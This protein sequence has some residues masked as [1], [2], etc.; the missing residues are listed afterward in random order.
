[1]N[2]PGSWP[3]GSA[4]DKKKR[5]PDS[6]RFFCVPPTLGGLL[7]RTR[8]ALLR[9]V[10]LT[11][12]RFTYSGPFYFFQHLE[13][14]FGRPDKQA[15]ERFPQASG[16]KVAGTVRLLGARVDTRTGLSL[17]RIALPQ[18]PDIRP[19][20]YARAMFTNITAPVPS[21]PEAAIHF[22][23]NGASLLTLDKQ[24]RAHRVGINT[25]RRQGGLEE[26]RKSVVLGTGCAVRVNL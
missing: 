20:G 6:L 3:G 10:L 26:A 4:I 21:V 23:A 5:R 11:Q 24:N 9:P 22:D 16:A 2:R 1:M 19:G 7:G 15:F 12:A 14:A 8:P 18:R 25:G 17:V 13:Y